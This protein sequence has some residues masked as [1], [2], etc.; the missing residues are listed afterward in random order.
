MSTVIDWASKPEPW[1]RIGLAW[2]AEC[3]LIAANFSSPPPEYS[4]P[5]S[6]ELRRRRKVL[7]LSQGAIAKAAGVST[8]SV[9]NAELH[10]FAGWA[11][12]KISDALDRLE[13]AQTAA[14]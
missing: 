4:A 5:V 2:A 7:G 13:A 3:S 14:K 8:A 11:P 1:R 6:S 12:G 10:K 9:S